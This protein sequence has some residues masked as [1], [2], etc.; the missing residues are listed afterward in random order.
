MSLNP[1]PPLRR[2]FGHFWRALDFSRR[3]VFN[4]IFLLIVLAIVYGIFG[5]G[6]KPLQQ[7]TTLV[8]NLQGQ[9]VEQHP[10]GARE[11]LLANIGGDGKKTVQLRD[12]LK[13][14]DAAGKDASIGGAVLILDDLQ[15]G[16]L[17][18]LREV[19]AALDRFRASGKKVTA[20]GSSYNQ[21]QYL[22]AAH[23]DE[24]FV[25]PM[26]GVMLEGFGRYRNY[27]RD[28]LDKLGVTVNLLKVGTY[29]S[30]AE[31]YIANGPSSAAA[32]AESYLNNALWSAY[33]G[34]VEKARK[35]PA[36][37]IMKGIDDLPALIA[38]ANGDLAKLAVNAKL[39]DGLKT[40][41]QVRELMIKRGAPDDDGKSFRQV[42][43]GDYLARQRSSYTGD[44]VGVVVAEGEIGDG[45]AAPGAIGGL[46]TSKLI[47]QAREDDRIKAVV[48]RVDSPGGSAFASELIRRE[49]ELTRAAGKPVVV[50]MG[51]VAASGG[52]WVSMS[53]DEV[54]ADAST[55]TGSIGVF[56]ILPTADK[57]I[58]KLGIHTA[59][60]PTT[61]LGDATNPLRPLD[62]RFAQ[63]IQ[64]SI[65][66]VY[67]EFTGKAA[68]ARKTTPE[69]INE[70]AQGR[71]WTGQQAKDRG[72]V[73]TIGSYGDAIASAARR[74]HLK[75]DY[76]VA[77][78]ERE[79]SRVDRL[80]DLVGGSAAQ[81]LGA[82][83]GA[84]LGEHVKLGLAGSGLPPDAAL[85]IAGDISWLSGL[86]REHRPFMALTHCLCESPLG[87]R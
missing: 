67:A 65:N 77:Y 70:V 24:V 63:V 50:S 16:G 66:H 82:T 33:T 56:A 53:S 1:F 42:A 73:D 52:Y 76:R 30:F 44:A 45:N 69:K 51:D 35:L 55:I 18:S 2:G 40:L 62:P 57:V 12:V 19:G 27:Y 83:I 85:G 80:I 43:F 13:V 48:L 72:L 17:A 46:S 9:L 8:L 26:G 5:G 22:V 23:A 36:G 31:P 32:E 11:A 3:L 84:S 7:K 21:R 29:K 81:A 86:A 87:S 74:A 4:L 6:L 47:R 59:G 34:E 28:A 78:I 61:W 49:L 54:I 41:D 64:S 39:V 14:L 60:A 10:G 38:A 15:G 25:H 71:V 37:A 79:G 68:Q 75:G 58:D 20:W